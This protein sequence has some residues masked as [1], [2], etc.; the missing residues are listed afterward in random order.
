MT[1]HTVSTRPHRAHSNQ[2]HAGLLASSLVARPATLSPA[3]LR[4]IVADILG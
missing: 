1:T 4:R 2:P 3:E